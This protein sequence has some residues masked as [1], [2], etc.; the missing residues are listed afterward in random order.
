MSAAGLIA[1]ESRDSSNR[2]PRWVT[3]GLATLALA[4]VAYVATGIIPQLLD[5]SDGG[6]RRIRR[7]VDALKAGKTKTLHLVSIRH[8]DTLLE[9]V[10][11]MPEIE[12]IYMENAD[13]TVVGM[14]HL[15]SLPNLRTV[16]VYTSEIGDE[17]M[18]ELRTCT[19]LESLAIYD[20]RITEDAIAKLRRYI[21]NIRI[22]TKHDEE[23]IG[24]T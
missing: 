17:G 2:P 10:R 3:I 12:D 24:G 15:G 23:P 8:T 9:Q 19:K 7:N 11:G 4:V 22:N 20:R 14:R 21:P 5:M 16:M 1:P 13:I 18:L 6:G